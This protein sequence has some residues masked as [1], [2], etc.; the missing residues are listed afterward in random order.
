MNK[1][2]LHL[3]V[4][5]DDAAASPNIRTCRQTAA[6]GS[7]AGDAPPSAAREFEGVLPGLKLETLQVLDAQRSELVAQLMRQ[8]ADQTASLHARMMDF[9]RWKEYR[10]RF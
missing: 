8:Q 5:D 10:K 7:S 1:L 4:G 3:R 6:I 9:E 2:I